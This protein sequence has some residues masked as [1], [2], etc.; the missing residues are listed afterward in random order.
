[1]KTWQKKAHYAVIGVTVLLLAVIVVRVNPYKLVQSFA[2]VAWRWVACVFALNLLHTWVE[3]FRWRLIL[4]SVK[5]ETRTLNTFGA[6]LVG[7]VGNTILPLRLGDGARAYF[8]ARR[9]HISFTSTLGTVML[10]R[11]IEVSSF[12]I[13][14]ILTGF[15]YNFSVAIK[16]A[17]F[18][19]V[20]AVGGAIIIL[21][22][23]VRFGPHLQL[24]FTGR[25]G[26]RFFGWIHRFALGL[27]SLKKA[28]VLVP[29]GILA[30]VSWG[31]GIL[32]IVA[33][34]KAFH[35]DLPYTAPV[36]V[37]IFEN[38][39]IAAVSTP[40]NIGGFELSIIAAFSLFGVDTASALSC[41]IVFHAVEVIPMVLLGLGALSLSGITSQEVLSRKVP[42][43]GAAPDN[44]DEIPEP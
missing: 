34:V 29:A 44:A 20:A 17:E 9:E 41:A 39:G 43:L 25:T 1:M 42:A 31:I 7:V 24:R 19:A 5:R 21:L 12:V 8:L 22:L 32:M 28:G 16:R 26:G 30:A 10:D 37:L 14:V 13:L 11:L 35:F 38:L 18:A 36:V 40:A 27:A 23:L 33:I 6:M 2:G 3:A 4:S 15:F